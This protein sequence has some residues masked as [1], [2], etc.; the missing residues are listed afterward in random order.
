MPIESYS[1]LKYKNDASV[2]KGWAS[3]SCSFFTSG[4]EI[5][6]NLSLLTFVLNNVSS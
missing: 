6:S 2:R 4:N 3:L 5:D 1:N